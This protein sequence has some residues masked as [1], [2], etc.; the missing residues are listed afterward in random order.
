MANVSKLGSKKKGSKKK[1][2]KKKGSK[3]GSKPVVVTSQPKPVVVVASQPKPVVA[4]QSKSDDKKKGKFSD[5]EIA[6]I[7][8][9]SICG[10]ILFIIGS[11]ALYKKFKKK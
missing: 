3:K 6:A 10:F 8:I 4:S 2:S 9:G 5:G 7:V 1:G 11:M